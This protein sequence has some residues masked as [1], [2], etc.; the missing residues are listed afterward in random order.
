MIRKTVTF[1]SLLAL[2]LS[3]GLWGV[4]YW[5]FFWLSQDTMFFLGIY[6]GAAQFARL[7]V[8]PSFE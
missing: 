4:S 1:L 7:Q 5:G 6:E 3:V 8:S 2:L